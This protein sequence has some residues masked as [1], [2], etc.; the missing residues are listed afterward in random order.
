MST[1]QKIIALALILCVLAGLWYA[2]LSAHDTAQK[3][4]TKLEIAQDTISGAVDEKR[5]V[6]K[7]SIKHA[8]KK[9]VALD[10]VGR[11]LKEANENA[12]LP[13]TCPDSVAGD[14]DTRLFNSAVADVNKL[15]DDS[16]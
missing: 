14:V 3:I 5:A 11:I 7:V 16:I 13:E 1:K 2:W 4:G 6:S 9:A 8:Q 10:S 15:I 12:P